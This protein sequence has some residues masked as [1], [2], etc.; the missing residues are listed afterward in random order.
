MTNP[1]FRVRIGLAVV[2]GLIGVA[3]GACNML[4]ESSFEIAASPPDAAA[5]PGDTMVLQGHLHANR[6]G[7]F[8][9]PSMTHAAAAKLALD[10]D[11]T[12][13]YDGQ[14]Y[15][16]PLY[17]SNLRPGVDAVFVVTQ[18][19]SVVALDAETGSTIWSV[20]FGD[21]V[22]PASLQCNQPVSQPYGI[23]STPVIDLDARTL[24]TFAWTS[25]D[26]GATTQQLAY[27]LSIDDGSVRPGWPVDI[28]ANVPGFAANLQH[29]RGSL[30]LLGGAL[31]IPFSGL[32]YDCADYRG[33]VVGISASEPTNVF[34][35][36]TMA[37]KGGIWGALASDGTSLFFVTGNHV[38]GTTT[39]SGGEAAIRLAQ[40]LSFSGTSHDYFTPSNWQALDTGDL[41]LGSSSIVLF[42][43]P[44]AGSGKLAVAMGKFG[45]VHL[46]D[47][48]NLGGLGT[49]NGVTGEGLYSEQ[50]ATKPISGNPASYTTTKGRYVVLRANSDGLLCPSGTSGDLMALLVAPTT[51]PTFSVAWCASTGGQ[52]SPIVT[53]T[54]GASD[55]IVWVVSAQGS[56]VLLGF[57]GDSGALIFAGGGIAMN[58]VLRWTSPIVVGK[59]IYV[60]ATNELY[61]F[62][63]P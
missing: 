52:G 2:T 17:V 4:S 23:L 35:W 54:D 16:Q 37:N 1:T 34:T 55:P 58:E 8:L 30:L 50:L 27:A 24:Y 26:Q 51:P 42:D 29:Q 6:D 39:W 43:L 63:L 19:N 5:P 38:S 21:I 3:T 49:G 45:T 56:N 44:G 46:V 13:F 62:E 12:G 59:R 36:S 22:P 7:A 9:A 11:F 32:A 61:A 60:G 48:E 31:Y 15:A 25:P 20:S 14:T 10:A 18:S 53:T 41:D 40:N 33:W 57:D 47:R 28:A